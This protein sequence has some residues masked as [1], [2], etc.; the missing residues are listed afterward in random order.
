[1]M[2]TIDQKNVLKKK[3]VEEI[4]NKFF[5]DRLFALQIELHRLVCS[6]IIL[7]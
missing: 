7:S 2:A 4:T 6:D 1:M 5:A 3:I